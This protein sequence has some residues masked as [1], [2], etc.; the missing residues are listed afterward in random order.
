MKLFD[1]HTHAFPDAIA[2]NAISK[3]AKTFGFP[4]ET[5]GTISDTVKKMK[6]WGV[7]GG[8]I[9]NIATKPSQADSIYNFCTSINEQNI[10]AFASVH[11]DDPNLEK[12]LERI[13]NGGL[14]GI[15]IHPDYQDFFVDEPRAFKIYKKCEELGLIVDFHA[16]FDFYAPVIFH[17]RP[18]LFAKISDGCPNLT[19]VLAHLGGIKLW[20]DVEKY[21]VG[22]KNIYLDTS[23]LY[24]FMQPEQTKRIILNHGAEN[25]LFGSDCP[26]ENPTDSLKYLKSLELTGQQMEL[27]CYKN[28]E[29][30]LNINIIKQ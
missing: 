6:S 16:G 28:A 13:K 3:L 20:D 24:R 25:I 2:E 4:P 12:N 11:P 22:R 5:D 30:L 27:I 10:V 7:D 23:M 21:I 19:I 1:F 15:K 14:K 29:R 17:G 9:L 26:W 8:V 18:D